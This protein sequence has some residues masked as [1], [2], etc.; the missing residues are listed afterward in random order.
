M[1]R[2]CYVLGGVGSLPLCSLCGMTSLCKSIECKKSYLTS[3]WP[4]KNDCCSYVLLRSTAEC[5]QYACMPS[6]TNNLQVSKTRW[7]TTHGELGMD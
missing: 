5:I 6:A 2:A 7:R 3:H 4:H 1:V